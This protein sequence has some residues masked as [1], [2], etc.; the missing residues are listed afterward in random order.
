[1]D[2]QSIFE[3]FPLVKAILTVKDTLTACA[4]W[5][6]WKERKYV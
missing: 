5:K 1:M 4:L 2:L 6:A 3:E